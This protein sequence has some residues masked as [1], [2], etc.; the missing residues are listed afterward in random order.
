MV[1]SIVKTNIKFNH[2]LMEDNSTLA[3]DQSAS[4]QPLV[5]VI[6]PAYNAEAYILHTLNSVLSQ[7]YK[8]IEVVVVDDGS[9]DGTVQIVE[10]IIQKD[11]RVILLR[12]PNSGVS[13]ARNR[14]I[15]KSRG[16]Y[17]APIDADD[18]WY[19]QKIEKQ[20][21]CMLHEGTSTGLVYA[22]S[23]QINKKGLLTGGYSA[24]PI[25]GDVFPALI[26]CNFIGNGSVP[27]IRRVCFDRI[28]GYN[29]H[30]EPC[31]DYDLQLRIAEFYKYRVVKEF[32]V[33]YRKVVGSRSFNYRDMETS[34]R[35]VMEDVKQQYSGIPSFVYLQSWSHYCLYLYCQSR[36][37]GH[38]W[39]SI[40]YLAKA[41]WTSP[42]FLLCP[43]FYRSLC[44]NVFRLVKQAVIFTIRAVHCPLARNFEMDSPT[45]E[46]I[47][48]S[49]I[50]IR[51]SRPPSGLSKL[52]LIRLQ[53][54]QRLV[55]EWKTVR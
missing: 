37:C 41:A 31:E 9:R 3:T 36:L 34:R 23:V 2:L 49:D 5:S 40:H 33:G 32:L 30:V 18:I 45:R 17:I 25:E 43:E 28:G 39:T 15:E 14:A 16:E 48:I 12:Q 4:D 54:I 13:V 20:V 10:T 53:R 27:L 29:T 47:A 8:N 7:T 55:A 11:D 50:V 35:I 22:W 26:M 42:A 1:K 38:H 51:S 46:E 44:S 24:F 52:H 19:S 21:N 6:I